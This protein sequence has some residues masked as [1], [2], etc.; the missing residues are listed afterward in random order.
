MMMKMMMLVPPTVIKAIQPKPAAAAAP[1]PAP[2]PS[3]SPAPASAGD[4]VEEEL[5]ELVSEMVK[6]KLGLKKA[7]VTF[8][9]SL[10]DVGIMSLEDLRLLPSDKARA[11]LEKSSMQELQIE[12]VVAAYKSSQ[13]TQ[14]AAPA[15]HVWSCTIPTF[16]SFPHYPPP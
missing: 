12:K 13:E 5:Q 8:A 1:A 16:T 9:R 7:C 2:A 6:L 4:D 11:M 15:K 14:V 3:P 10:A